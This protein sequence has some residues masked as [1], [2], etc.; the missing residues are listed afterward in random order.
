MLTLEL[1]VN[2]QLSRYAELR[3]KKDQAFLFYISSLEQK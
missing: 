3:K 2:G 1:L